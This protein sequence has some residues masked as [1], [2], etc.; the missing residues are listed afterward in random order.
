MALPTL[1]VDR[2]SNS[3][4]AFERT[5]SCFGSALCWE[6]EH[7]VALR[8]LLLLDAAAFTHFGRTFSYLEVLLVGV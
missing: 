5:S 3:T 2:L 8:D 4:V 6:V 7:R 1:F